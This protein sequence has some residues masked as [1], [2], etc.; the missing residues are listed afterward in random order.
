MTWRN[1]K[2]GEA[3]I[4][5]VNQRWPGRSK[6]SDGTIGDPAHS[7]RTS[8]HNPNAA[9]VVRA[10][11]ITAAG[12][13]AAWFADWLRSKGT[14]G[15]PRLIGGGYIIFNRRI[16]RPDF[17]GWRVYTGQNPHVKHIHV[18]FTRNAGPLGYDNPSNWGLVLPNKAYVTTPVSTYCRYGEKNTRVMDL[19]KFMTRNFPSYNSYKPTG[20]YGEQTKAGMAEFQRRVG[21]TGPDA[22]GSIVGPRTMAKLKANG[23]QP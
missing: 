13:D 6:A 5:E 17:Q 11:D 1:C 18:S 20:L 16:T 23:F 9:G 14:D 21:V 22:D 19:Q 4:R 15:D 3:L 12:T 10:R 2:A 7:A 8:D